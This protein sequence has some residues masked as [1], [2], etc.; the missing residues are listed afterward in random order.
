MPS[1]I[2]SQIDAFQ[3]EG[4]LTKHKDDRKRERKKVQMWPHKTPSLW[5]IT[6]VM[7]SKKKCHTRWK[8]LS[9]M[10][11]PIIPLDYLC[12]YSPV[13]ALCLLRK[14]ALMSICVIYHYPHVCSSA[15]L[16]R[17]FNSYAVKFVILTEINYKL[18]SYIYMTSDATWDMNCQE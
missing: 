18:T 8:Y 2:Q 5:K 14:S 9:Y 10:W 3:N 17:I 15:C 1:P 12:F 16:L 6:K 13:R 7:K 4:C 11:D